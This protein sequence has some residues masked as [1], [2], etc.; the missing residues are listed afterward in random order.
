ML[1]FDGSCFIS[2][3]QYAAICSAAGYFIKRQL[4]VPI[5]ASGA[6]RVGN[7]SRSAPYLEYTGALSGK[8]DYKRGIG[9]Y[10]KKLFIRPEWQGSVFSF[11]SKERTV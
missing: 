10:E 1:P 9:N 7:K 11:V 3:L 2:V 5:L 4:E 6:E 8:I